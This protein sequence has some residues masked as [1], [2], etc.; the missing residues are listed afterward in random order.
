M[1]F[2]T[3]DCYKL[4]FKLVK[5]C[6]HCIVLACRMRQSRCK[7]TKN[8]WWWPTG[9]SVLLAV[10]SLIRHVFLNALGDHYYSAIHNKPSERFHGNKIPS[11]WNMPQISN[12]VEKNLAAGKGNFEIG[13]GQNADGN[14]LW[15]KESGSLRAKLFFQ[16]I[17]LLIALLWLRYRP[18][19]IQCDWLCRLHLFHRHGLK[20][21]DGPMQK[22]DP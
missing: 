7:E 19:A 9:I 15:K 18:R 12:Q 2:C 13:S 16:I 20:L 6:Y 14:N 5:T 22:N 8:R 1:A 21:L 17:S 11:C 3:A 10:W 4:N